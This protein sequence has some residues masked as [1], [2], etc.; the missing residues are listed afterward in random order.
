MLMHALIP[1]LQIHGLTKAFYGF[2]AVNGLDLV[3]PAGQ[4]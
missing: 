2:L 3:G 1:A 4:I